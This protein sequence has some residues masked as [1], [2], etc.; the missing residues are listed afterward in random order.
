MLVG[1]C[2]STGVSPSY[3]F[4]ASNQNGLIV[5]GFSATGAQSVDFNIGRFNAEKGTVQLGTTGG[6]KSIT[7][8]DG[9]TLRFYVL[10]LEPGDYVFKSA[11]VTASGYPTTYVYVT[12]LADSTYR[13]EVEPGKLKYVGNLKY[14][15]DRA[16]FSR[17]LR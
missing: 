6:V 8:K 1:A 13:F 3:Q 10:D 9:E 16:F 5:F 17:S 15:A 14:G 2:A 12:C 11:D 4:A 7:H